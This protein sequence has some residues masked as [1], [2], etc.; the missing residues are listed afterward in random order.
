MVSKK[1][2]VSVLFLVGLSIFV[3]VFHL[4]GFGKIVSNLVRLEPLYY[5]VAVG[6][7]CFT[8]LLWSSRWWLFVKKHEPSVTY[9]EILK[10]QIIGLA[11][12]NMTPVAKMGGEP[13]KAYLLKG[14]Y[15]LRM[16]KGL[17]TILSDLTLEFIASISLVIVAMFLYLVVFS[18]PTWMYIILSLFILFSLVALAGIMGV[19][20]RKNM[21]PRL[22]KWAGRK[23]KKLEPYT[24]RMIE[25]YEDFQE[26]FRKGLKDKKTLSK[27]MFLSGLMKVSEIVKYYFIFLA[28]GYSIGLVELFIIMGIT[29]MLL[30]IPATPGS[31]GILEGGLI[32][33]FVLLGVPPDIAAAAVFLDRLV[34]FWGITAAGSLIG[35][36]HGISVIDVRGG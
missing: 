14:K 18:P 28:M 25:G 36:Y 31:L 4:I 11:I 33:T 5:G 21:L 35:A 20:S 30:T 2:K 9:S 22:I 1:V 10:D 27:G 29:A 12:N 13:V 32:S 26:A 7:I 17:A 8:V 24:K 6:L 16:R 19:Y 34:W 15:K 23:S 3:G